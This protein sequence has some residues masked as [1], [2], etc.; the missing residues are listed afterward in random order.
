[1]VQQISPA[2]LEEII[3]RHDAVKEACCFGIHDTEGGDRIPRMVV[4]LKPES[5]SVS[6]AELQTFVNSKL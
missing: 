5:G 4:T 2:E 6:A 1:M 3:L